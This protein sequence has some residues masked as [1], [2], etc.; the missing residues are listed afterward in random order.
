MKIEAD[1]QR[2]LQESENLIGMSRQIRKCGAQAES[3]WAR[4]GRYTQ[5]DG[6][7]QELKKQIE[8]VERITAELTLLASAL[9]D[10]ANRYGWTEQKNIEALDGYSS[11]FRNRDQMRF[12]VIPDAIIEQ[13]NSLLH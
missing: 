6:C 1:R 11:P 2:L 8:T 5:L 3:I 12:T 13:F 9:Q 4:L 7:R 10:I